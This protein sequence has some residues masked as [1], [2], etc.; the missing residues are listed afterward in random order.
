[1]FER[2][3]NSISLSSTTDI[4]K[5]LAEY[6]KAKVDETKPIIEPIIQPIE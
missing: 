3:G 5:K 4:A 2:E 6:N 1:L